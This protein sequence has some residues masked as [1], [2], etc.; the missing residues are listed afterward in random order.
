MSLRRGRRIQ[1]L[2]IQNIKQV[3]RKFKKNFLFVYFSRELCPSTSPQCFDSFL[4]LSLE[5]NGRQLRKIIFNVP[6]HYL[7]WVKMGPES[8]GTEARTFFRKASKEVAWAGT[9]WSGQ[10]VKWY[11]ITSRARYSA[12]GLRKVTRKVSILAYMHLSQL[13]V[14]LYYPM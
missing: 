4:W 1:K 3:K 12:S 9:L 8:S 2:P 14:S 5:R 7:Q 13:A 10:A 6:S 11:C